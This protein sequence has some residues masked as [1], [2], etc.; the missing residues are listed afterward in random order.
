M[1]L[2]KESF[3]TAI[4][5]HQKWIWQRLKYTLTVRVLSQPVQVLIF[6][7]IQVALAG[8]LEIH[9]FTVSVYFAP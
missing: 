4:S 8:F 7:R 6:K 1:E 9:K 5:F 3:E 2:V